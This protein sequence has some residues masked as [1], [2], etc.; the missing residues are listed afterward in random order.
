MSKTYT[1]TMSEAQT[2][3]LVRALDLYSR[4]GIGQ[5]E[6]I[7]R[8]YDPISSLV[9]IEAGDSARKLLDAVKAI[10][11]HPANGSNGLLNPEVRDEFRAACDIQQIVSHQ[12]ALDHNQGKNDY[13]VDYYEPRQ[14][15]QLSLPSIK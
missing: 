10:Y 8:V 9:P 1:L 2:G 4:I 14:L 6:E 15:S 7:L 12:L 3:I 11:G 5:F 13:T